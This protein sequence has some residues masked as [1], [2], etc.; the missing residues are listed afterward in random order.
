[1]A[2]PPDKCL[3]LVNLLW[4]TTLYTLLSNSLTNC[5]FYQQNDDLAIGRPASSTN[6]EVLMQ[7]NGQTALDPSRLWKRVVDDVYSIHKQMLLEN[8]FYH[9]K[10][11]YQNINVTIEAESNGELALSS[12]LLK[13]N[14]GKIC[15]LVYRKPTHSDQY[16]YYS[17]PHQTSCKR[18]VVCS[19]F[20]RA[21][22]IIINKDDLNSENSTMKQV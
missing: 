20:S 18:I 12:T 6:I 22:S 14:N 13:Q 8:F 4:T 9:I 7:A 16:L 21:Y 2:I 17:S 5:R 10:N 1:M 3:D 11:L 15:A 19:L